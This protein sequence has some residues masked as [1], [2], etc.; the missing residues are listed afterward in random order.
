MLHLY[1]KRL[2]GNRLGSK[3]A[4]RFANCVAERTSAHRQSIAH[5]ELSAYTAHRHSFARATH[6]ESFARA[7]DDESFARAA[8][9]QS[10]ADAQCQPPRTTASGNADADC[11]ATRTTNYD[12]HHR[13]RRSHQCG[14]R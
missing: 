9:R 6:R 14:A 3:R 7:A 13:W 2:A 8:H 4:E 1:C 11:N 12:H 5:R 10:F